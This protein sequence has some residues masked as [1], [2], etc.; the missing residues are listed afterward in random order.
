MHDY[1][2][3]AIDVLYHTRHRAPIHMGRSILAM[4]L[5]TMLLVT[6]LAISHV[7]VVQ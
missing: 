1:I 2:H 7:S 5:V 3:G 4:L 6:I